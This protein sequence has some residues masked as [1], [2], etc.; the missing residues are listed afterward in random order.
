MPMELTGWSTVAFC[1]N[2][3]KPMSRGY[4]SMTALLGL[5]AIAGYQNRDK[6]AEMLGGVGQ[7][8][9]GSD[10][11]GGLGGLLGPARSRRCKCRWDPQR[12]A[13]RTFGALQAERTKRNRR[14]LGQHW[15]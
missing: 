5:L 15:S 2:R 10:K 12:W 8:K 1:Q 11:Q 9:P 14:V 7:N 6:I 13:R 4:P 3:S